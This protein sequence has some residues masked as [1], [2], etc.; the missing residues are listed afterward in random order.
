MKGILMK[1]KCYSNVNFHNIHKHGKF[2]PKAEASLTNQKNKKKKKD[3]PLQ[4]NVLY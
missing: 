2:Y 3:P 1:N 4:H